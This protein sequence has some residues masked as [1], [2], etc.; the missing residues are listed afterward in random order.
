MKRWLRDSLRG[1]LLVFLLVAVILS[2]AMQTMIAYRNAL[3]ET[4]EIFDFQMQQIA[5]SL[6]SGLPNN[7][8]F[9]N[10][11]DGIDDENFAFV[12]QVFQ[13]NGAKSYQSNP[14]VDLLPQAHIGFSTIDVPG[15]SFRVFSLQS[16]GRQIQI[17]Q[18][19]AARELMAR[20][21]ALRTVGPIVLLAPLLMVAV[22]WTVSTSLAPV[23]R[24][25]KQLAKR[26]GGD[27]GKLDL[28]GLP[29][30][31][32]PLGNELN[33]LLIRI[34]EAFEA[35]QIFVSDAAHE[36]RSPLAALKLQAMALRRA[37]EPDVQET[38]LNRLD[39]G[40]ER[41][42][43]VVEQLLTLARQ[44]SNECLNGMEEPVR[45]GD[46][47][48]TGLSD[49]VALAD[50]KHLDIQ[51]QLKDDAYISAD[52]SQLHILVRNVL[53]NAI[54][55]NVDQGRIVVSIQRLQGS[56]TLSI[57]DSGPGI[58]ESDYVRVFDRFY[59]IA[60][61]HAVGSGL[62]L[63]IVKAIAQ[64]HSATVWLERS[65][66]LGGLKVSVKFPLG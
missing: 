4:D 29:R 8:D 16:G 12:I 2:A 59:R 42:T 14:Y 63:S 34:E 60:G 52:Q 3:H 58:P 25:R 44:E 23:D 66:S 56:V 54:K 51:L 49:L 30:E 28:H 50:N 1:R 20:N 26:A 7:A 40:I 39:A 6:R 21:L 62:G 24:L 57:E 31:I 65:P 11:I 15:T 9:G 13:A 22:W 38:A 36:L 61:E 5:L 48:Q 33:L 27:S 55:Y 43:R 45:L 19:T 53:D 64:M 32:A 35:Q 41:A 10:P 17:S 46:I 47:V 37:R 18:D